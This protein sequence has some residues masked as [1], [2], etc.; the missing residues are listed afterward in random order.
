ME[1]DWCATRIFLLLLIISFW[2]GANGMGNCKEQARA[3]TYFIFVINIDTPNGYG[4]YLLSHCLC[5]ENP[6][7]VFLYFFLNIFMPH[8]R[9]KEKKKREGGRNRENVKIFYKLILSYCSN[10]YLFLKQKKIRQ[11]KRINE[12]KR[13]RTEWL[14]L[15][16]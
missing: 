14:R 15:C 1:N 8:D 16:P 12:W 6:C 3:E 13:K 11:R 7:Q 2:N 4:L 9:E 5:F 10:F